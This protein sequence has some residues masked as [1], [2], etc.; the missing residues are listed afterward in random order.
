MFKQYTNG[1]YQVLINP[2]TGTKIRIN[3]LDFFSPSQPE[4]IDLKITNRCNM[5]CLF[6]HEDSSPDGKH[7]DIDQNFFCTFNKYQEVALGGG[8]VLE[9]PELD[10]LLNMLKDQEV[11]PSITINQRHFI[12]DFERIYKLYENNLIYGV[13]VSLN[14]SSDPRLVELLE[15]IPTSVIHSINGLLTKQDIENLKENNLKLLILGYKNLRRGEEYK[16]THNKEI[17]QNME[18]LVNNLKYVFNCFSIVSFDNLALAQLPVKDCIDED[19]W[20]TVYMGDDGVFTYYVD[21]VEK[22]FA[23]SSTSMSRKDIKERTVNEMYSIIRSE[24]D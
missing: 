10:R 1:N 7:A 13:G 4:S 6:C 22:K 21:A 18:F 23:E 9:H 14:D 16:K 20:N 2:K 24:N 11:F 8:N 5:N 19:S 12:D 17:S 15:K 3:D